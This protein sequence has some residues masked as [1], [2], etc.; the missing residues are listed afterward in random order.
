MELLENL[1]VNDANEMESNVYSEVQIE[2]DDEYEGQGPFQIS[3]L[4][5]EAL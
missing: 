2:E 3:I 1:L 5:P 4:R